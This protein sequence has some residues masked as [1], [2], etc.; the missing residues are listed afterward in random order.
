[1]SYLNGVG[2][3]TDLRFNT[4]S[5]N[6]R[7]V[8]DINGNAKVKDMTCKDLKVRKKYTDAT[9]NSGSTGDILTSTGTSTQWLPASSSMFQSGSTRTYAYISTNVQFQV[10]DDIGFDTI[11]YSDNDFTP[12]I[13]NAVWTCNPG[14]SGYYMI[15]LQ[16]YGQDLQGAVSVTMQFS[17]ITGGTG[18]LYPGMQVI[19]AI[20]NAM[21]IVTYIGE[22]DTFSVKNWSAGTFYKIPVDPGN[23]APL[24]PLS[25]L[26]MTR[27]S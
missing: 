7:Q 20:H 13:G 15:Q 3:S 26:M 11:A 5:Q 19:P 21:N 27:L 2:N 4:L 17:G 23:S 25:W 6:G 9:G 24:V 16:L 22:G 18:Q 14:K 12:D 10:G 1:M 8:I